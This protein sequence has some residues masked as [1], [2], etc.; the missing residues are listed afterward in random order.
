MEM[1]S[2]EITKPIAAVGE[3]ND[4]GYDAIFPSDGQVYLLRKADGRRLKIERQ[5]NVF[6]LP[7]TGFGDVEN[8]SP[9]PPP[10]GARR[11]QAQAARR[12]RRP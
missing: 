9:P 1:Q 5:N 12:D 3:L 2:A 8:G 11:A 6:W 4:A 10:R 7:T